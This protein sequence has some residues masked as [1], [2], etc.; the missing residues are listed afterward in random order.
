MRQGILICPS[1]VEFILSVTGLKRIAR[2][3]NL[4]IFKCCSC[5]RNPNDVFFGRKI[6]FTFRQKCTKYLAYD[7]MICSNKLLKCSFSGTC[8]YRGYK[9]QHTV[10][11]AK[12]LQC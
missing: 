1:K 7:E 8:A 2:F 12:W 3:E 11:P 4:I 6:A 5:A 9:R 10:F